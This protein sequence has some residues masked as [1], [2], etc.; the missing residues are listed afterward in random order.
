MLLTPLLWRGVGSEA[1]AQNKD[2]FWVFGDSAGINFSTQ[3]FSTLA[4]PAR[5]QGGSASICDS[6][7]QLL[8]YA[9]PVTDLNLID[10]NGLVYNRNLQIMPNGDSIICE[11]FYKEL[12]IIPMPLQQNK[13]YLFSNDVVNNLGFYYSVVDMSLNGGYG[14]IVQKNIIVTPSQYIDA[15]TAVRHANGRDWWLVMHNSEVTNGRKDFYV[16][17]I[18]STG[19]S[20]PMHQQIGSL[21]KTGFADIRFSPDG[22]RLVAINYFG[23]IELFDFDRCTGVLSNP[24]LISTANGN[25]QKIYFGCSFSTNSNVLYVSVTDNIIDPNDSLRLYQFDLL[26]PNI[27]ASKITIYNAVVPASGGMQALGPDGKIYWSCLYKYGYPY[28]DSVRNMYNENLSVINY[29]DSLGLACDFQPFSFYL[30]G[31][32]C[33]WGLPNNANYELGAVSGSVCDSLGLAVNE[34]ETPPPKLFIYYHSAWQTAFINAQGLKGKNYS[35][36]V[37]DLMGN[38]IYKEEG[39]LNSAY[40]TRDLHI[41]DYAGGMYV[42]RISTNKEQLSGKF[43]KQ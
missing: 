5:A 27:A 7:G 37:Y 21:H 1:L 17:L 36:Q 28:A 12:K 3:P 29:P 34:I 43:V 22:S 33:Y 15:I 42:V 6:A 4:T 13:C 24:Q 26:A 35:M 38:R 39:K 30:G 9:R 20:S 19:I 41:A 18:S 8:F 16:Y 25:P 14:D 32:R 23:L 31:K 10:F 2:S 11:G 40:Y